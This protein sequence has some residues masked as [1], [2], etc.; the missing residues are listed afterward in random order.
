MSQT[1]CHFDGE[2]VHAFLKNVAAFPTGT[3]VKLSDGQVA[4]VVHNSPGNPLRP[5]I[6]IADCQSPTKNDIDLLTDRQY[7][8]VTIIGMGYE[9]ADVDFSCL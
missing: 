9:D 8:N 6:R 7:T 5:V 4:I 3:C 1:H 2:V